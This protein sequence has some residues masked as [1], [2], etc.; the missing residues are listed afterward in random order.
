MTK[1]TQEQA[2]AIP[3]VALTDEVGPLAYTIM[4]M[5]ADASTPSPQHGIF[6]AALALR[7][8]VAITGELGGDERK[9]KAYAL[10]VVERLLDGPFDFSDMGGTETIIA[11]PPKNG[12]H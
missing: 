5:I 1:R 7:G 3:V 9:F 12:Q 8:L 4:D 2:D 10:E 11:V 6:A